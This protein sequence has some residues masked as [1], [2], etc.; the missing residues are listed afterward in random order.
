MG[1][2]GPSLEQIIKR[3]LLGQLQTPPVDLNKPLTYG[4]EADIRLKIIDEKAIPKKSSKK[5]T[6]PTDKHDAKDKMSPDKKTKVP[7]KV[8]GPPDDAEMKAERIP[9][10]TPGKD[11][12]EDDMNL[13]D[14]K[15]QGKFPPKGQ[16]G[17]SGQ[18]KPGMFPKA[19]NLQTPEVKGDEV[20]SLA[21]IRIVPNSD[22][23]NPNEVTFGKKTKVDVR[24]T[25]GTNVSASDKEDSRPVREA[26]DVP[27][28]KI[29]WAKKM[30]SAGLNRPKSKWDHDR[31][32]EEAQ[33]RM[34]YTDPKVHDSMAKA[35]THHGWYE[36][37]EPN[38][39]GRANSGHSSV[40]EHPDH[41][42]HMM[43]IHSGGWNHIGPGDYYKYSHFQDKGAGK[44]TPLHHHLAKFHKVNEQRVD[45]RIKTKSQL[46]YKADR[47]A[48]RAEFQAGQA[49]AYGQLGLNISART[50]ARKA[51]LHNKAAHIANRM[52]NKLTKSILKPK[53]SIKIDEGKRSKKELMDKTESH[54]EK[55][56]KAHDAAYT[57]I[58]Q[59][60]N[61]LTKGNKGVA[62]LHSVSAK[63]LVRRGH[64]HKKAAR[65]AFKMFRKPFVEDEAMAKLDVKAAAW[66]F[67]PQPYHNKE[68]KRLL[69]NNG[70]LKEEEDE[71]LPKLD[72]KAAVGF[73][74]PQ[75]LH[76]QGIKKLIR[77]NRKL[78]EMELNELGRAHNKETLLAFARRRNLQAKTDSE[79]SDKYPDL[80]KKAALRRKAAFKATE[81]AKQIKEQAGLDM[82]LY[83]DINDHGNIDGPV[84]RQSRR[85]KLRKEDLVINSIRGALFRIDEQEKDEDV[86]ININGYDFLI[87]VASTPEELQQ[88][89]MHREELPLNVGMLFDFDHDKMLDMWMHET[90]IP[91]DMLFIDSDGVI[92]HIASDCITESDDYISSVVPVRY[93]LE[94]NAGLCEDIGIEEGDT[95]FL[96]GIK[97]FFQNLDGNIAS[98]AQRMYYGAKKAYYTHKL[99]K[100]IKAADSAKAAKSATKA[101][102]AMKK[103][104]SK[105][106]VKPSAPPPPPPPSGPKG[107]PTSSRASA[108]ASH[109]YKAALKRRAKTG[110]GP[111]PKNPNPP[112]GTASNPQHKTVTIIHQ[113]SNPHPPASAPPHHYP[114]KRSLGKAIGK[115]ALRFGADFLSHS[116]FGHTHRRRRRHSFWD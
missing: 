115:A 104:R 28:H 48:S 74:R 27:Y 89:L 114:K 108:V 55:S 62:E 79:W 33:Y 100:A 31:E 26:I 49:E 90:Y 65:T 84:A 99:N 42:D 110:F 81:R 64:L 19:N 102:S 76:K 82:P 61:D 54:N 46:E 32:K 29:R 5:P 73:W 30:T 113:S 85:K 23:S 77:K 96:E 37:H 22:I 11:A 25:F 83:N 41:K 34:D 66:L 52:R 63:A 112:R 20:G 101:H 116:L 86:I 109:N 8:G 56:R 13:S 39:Y 93:V 7:E 38:V 44:Y 3:R 10:K 2:I 111:V 40:W 72:V 36:T 67:R 71:S 70:K 14:P 21:P 47:H 78:S 103:T 105:A 43:S 6:K 15:N 75:I 91:L 69:R 45:E 12:H 18:Q 60:F 9:K 1:K 50:V 4:Q 58:H 51:H 68:I 94:I 24:P 57:H 88:G 98:G 35:L 80:R 106:K 87:E 16:Q 53:S 59:G 95:I 107:K 97:R 92:Q 17:P